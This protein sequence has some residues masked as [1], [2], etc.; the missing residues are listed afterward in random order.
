MANVNFSI[1]ENGYAPSE[2]D[3]YIDMLQQEYTNA[4]AWGQEMEKNL[5]ELKKQMQDLGVYF[6]IDENNQNEVIDRVFSELTQTVNKV[7]AE[8]EAKSKE[9]ID[10]ANEKSRTIV[11]QAMEN[12]VELRT[13]NSLVMK[14]LKSIS[15]MIDVIL[16]KASQ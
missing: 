7:K 4:V 10:K 2:V 1:I 3:K 15:D 13:Q 5:E 12:S 16:D 8:A 6:T 11:R 14:N 9:I